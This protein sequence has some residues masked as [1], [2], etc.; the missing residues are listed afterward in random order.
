MTADDRIH[1]LRV[2]LA[3]L[4]VRPFAGGSD[5]GAVDRVRALGAASTAVVA[6]VR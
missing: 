4:W 3:P 5:G 2:N 6:A 1:A